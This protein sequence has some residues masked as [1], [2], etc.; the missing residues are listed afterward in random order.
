MP[1][2]RNAKRSL[3]IALVAVFSAPVLAG[4]PIFSTPT[5]QL[6]GGGP[7][8]TG[9]TVYKGQK[10]FSSLFDPGTEWDVAR[11]HIDSFE[12]NTQ[13][14]V[15]G[16]DTLLKQVFSYLNDHHIPLALEGL[17][18]PNVGGV[19][20]G[21]EGFS[22][23]RGGMGSVVARIKMLGGTLSSISM[24]EP[25]YFGH[26]S[27]QMNA[28]Q[29][30]ISQVAHEVALNVEAVR[31]VFPQVQIGDI[32]PI[33]YTHDLQSWISAYEQATGTPLAFLK[34]DLNY[35]DS[36]WLSSLE[37]TSALLIQNNIPLSVIFDGNSTDTSNISSIEHA[38]QD[39]VQVL[40]DPKIKLS[41]AV[42]QSWLPYPTELLPDYDDGTSTNLI[43]K[44]SNAIS[45]VNIVS[46]P[47]SFLRF[48]LLIM[49]VFF[50]K[51]RNHKSATIAGQPNTGCIRSYLLR[52]RRSPGATA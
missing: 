12:I 20:S 8:N 21:V 46:E 49:S 42:V 36:T 51:V 16:S 10:G 17:M 52:A 11:A 30:S 23:P 3:L 19:G 43:V 1:V 29:W 26:Q 39:F 9:S 18:L 44:M 22:G 35:I 15:W 40:R 13:F 7:F 34:A 6:Y 31:K 45:V 47:E 37:S 24:D 38:L 41:Q 25:L 27:N 28:P 50:L 5:I 4:P 2:L 48:S 32:E 33:Q 14:V